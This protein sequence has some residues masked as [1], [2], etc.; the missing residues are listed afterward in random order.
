MYEYVNSISQE[1]IS[2]FIQME[3]DERRNNNFLKCLEVCTKIVLFN[4]LAN[5]LH[6]KTGISRSN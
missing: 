6:I 1:E 2:K 3:K 4:Y 5:V